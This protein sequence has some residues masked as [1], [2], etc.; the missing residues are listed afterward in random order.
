[1]NNLFSVLAAVAIGACLSVQPPINATMARA[2]GSPLL[3]ACISVTISLVF[4]IAVW[5]VSRGP[6]GELAQLSGLPWW[7]PLGG[8]VGVCFVVGGVVVAPEL[9]VALFFVC[10]VAGQLL[11]AT[12]VDQLGAFGAAVKPLNLVKLAGLAL[13][14]AGAA[15]VRWS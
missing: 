6:R 4:V 9:G 14:L 7:V 8:I 11:G 10:V 5:L 1:M 2:L 13:V 15:M 3:A 12:V